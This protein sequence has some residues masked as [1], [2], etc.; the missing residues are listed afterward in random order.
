MRFDKDV[1]VRDTGMSRGRVRKE[2]GREGQ[3]EGAK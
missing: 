2:S 1:R 3:R